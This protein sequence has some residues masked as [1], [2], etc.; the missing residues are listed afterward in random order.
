[1]RNKD[2]RETL[3]C[4]KPLKLYGLEGMFSAR[5]WKGVEQRGYSY[6]VSFAVSCS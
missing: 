1:M 6:G 5:I 2:S 4:W 3:H